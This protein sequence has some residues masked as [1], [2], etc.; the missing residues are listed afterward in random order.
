MDNN[1]Q[2]LWLQ[3]LAQIIGQNDNNNNG[4]EGQ[5]VTD[6]LRSRFSDIAAFSYSLLSTY[7][8][9]RSPRF[10]NDN[11]SNSA[12]PNALLAQMAE[13]IPGNSQLVTN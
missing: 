3:A 2:N 10:L 7:T 1:A 11:S 5:K 13:L 12:W 6:P 8:L 4:Q 9:L